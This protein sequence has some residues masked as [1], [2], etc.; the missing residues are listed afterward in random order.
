[1][2]KLFLSIIALLTLSVGLWAQETPVLPTPENNQIMYR[3][4]DHLFFNYSHLDLKIFK[5]RAKD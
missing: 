4:S 1:M 2:R 5:S 3:S